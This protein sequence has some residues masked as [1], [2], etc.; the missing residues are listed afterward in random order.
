[1]NNEKSFREHMALNGFHYD[2]PLPIG[3]SV[4]FDAVDKPGKKH[5]W[6]IFHNYRGHYTDNRDSEKVFTWSL[7]SKKLSKKQRAELETT[8][9]QY[10]GE[11][12]KLRL[13]AKA[14]AEA[15]MATGLIDSGTHA[16]LNSKQVGSYGL[17]FNK[18]E[19][20]DYIGLPL[21]DL[22]GVLWN[23]QKIYSYKPGNSTNKWNLTGGRKKGCFHLIG[24]TL[25]QLS[26]HKRVFIVEGYATGATAHMATEEPVIVTL[27][28]SN[29]IKVCRLLKEA[30]AKNIIVAS[31]DDGL[32]IKKD[33]KNPG[34][35]AAK[36]IQKECGFSYIR[37]VFDMEKYPE[38]NPPS[39]LN[40]IHVH[41]GLAAVTKILT[42]YVINISR[43]E[44]RGIPFNDEEENL[45]KILGISTSATYQ[46]IKTAFHTL[47]NKY[48]PDKNKDCE[49]SKSRMRKVNLA[50]EILKNT[51]KRNDYDLTCANKAKF[52]QQQERQ[53]KRKSYTPEQ[54]AEK[55]DLWMDGE[56]DYRA[57]SSGHF[58]SDVREE[59]KQ[60][61][62]AFD[63]GETNFRGTPIQVANRVG[64]DLEG[65]Y[66]VGN[67]IFDGADYWAYD[68]QKWKKLFHTK[69]FSEIKSWVDKYDNTP[70]AD[71]HLRDPA[72]GIVV[73]SKYKIVVLKSSD[74]E[75]IKN[76]IQNKFA[77]REFFNCVKPLG[78]NCSNGFLE[79]SKK[80]E[81]RL[82]LHAPSLKQK[83]IIEAKWDTS[84]N[85]ESIEI[86]ENSLLFKFLKGC[87][88]GLS[89]KEFGEVIKLICEILGA[90]ASGAG[91]DLDLNHPRAFFLIGEK[92]Y[93]GKSQFIQLIQLFVEKEYRTAVPPEKFTD[94][95]ELYRLK[96]S[97][98]NCTNEIADAG[99]LS[100]DIFKSVITF[101]EV[102]A[103]DLYKSSVLFPLK[104]I[105][106]YAGNQMPV[107][108]GGW[109]KGVQRRINVIPFDRI[110]PQDERL[111]NIAREII[112][113][114]KTL[115]LRMAA[116][117]LKRI[118]QNK[119][120]T[121]IPS[122][123]ENFYN[124]LV[125]ADPFI[126]WWNDCVEVTGLPESKTS[127][128]DAYENFTEY[129]TD[130]HHNHSVGIIKFSQ[131]MKGINDP[132][133]CYEH[134]GGFRGF[135]GIKLGKDPKPPKI[136]P[137][138][139]DK[140]LASS[141]STFSAM[142]N[143]APQLNYRI[144]NFPK[145]ALHEVSRFADES[146]KNIISLD[147]ETTG[148]EP[149]EGHTAR[150]LQ[151][152]NG[153]DTIVVDLFKTG[154]LTAL[155][156]PL[157]RM[158]A[159]AHNAV[160]E[161]KF[162]KAAGIDVTLDCTMIAAHCMAM[163]TKMPSLAVLVRKYF[164]VELDK[165]YQKAD[166]S[167]ELTTKQYA[168]A[169]QDAYYTFALWKELHKEL[170]Q[171]ECMAGYVNTRDA[172]KA[173]VDIE[174][175]GMSFDAL[176]HKN[177]IT[178]LKQNKETLLAKLQTAMPTVKNFNSGKQLTVWLKQQFNHHEDTETWEKTKA[179]DLITDQKYIKNSLHF[180]NT[181]AQ[182]TLTN[183][184][185]PY[186]EVEKKL[187]T[188]GENFAKE[189]ISKNTGHIHSQV[190]L[191]GTKTGRTASWSPNIQQTPRDG[192][193]RKLYRADE[194]KAFV[195]A[196]YSQIELRIAAIYV[197]EKALLKAYN[198]EVDTH[199]LTASLVLSKSIEEVTKFDRQV[200]KAVNF[201]LL[202]GQTP[203]GLKNYAKASYDVEM[204]LEEAELFSQKW[205]EHY[206]A[207]KNWHNKAD[208]KPWKANIS[209]RTQ[210]GRT[211][212]F[213]AKN[214]CVDESGKWQRD[215]NDRVIW[216]EEPG[217]HYWHKNTYL[218]TPIQG[219]GADLLLRAIG[220][221]YQRLQ[222]FEAHLVMV[223]H[224]EIILE[225]PTIHAVH[226]KEVLEKAMIEAFTFMY[227]EACTKGLVEAKIGNSWGD[228]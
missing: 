64:L 210:L 104:A 61:V 147:L 195:I 216:D 136:A 69:D 188:Y 185:V 139:Q 29:L 47:A 219:T 54:D 43:F 113:K 130:S 107:F 115:L 77:N 87:F 197:Q 167:A 106:I 190:V 194:G 154:G 145:E 14:E 165:T 46:E 169:A 183:L 19:Y 198:D 218:N 28:A 96:D 62:L 8:K 84:W 90:V 150:L 16:Y 42:E 112:E 17:V 120:Y 196:D 37:P 89:E 200:A 129:A 125:Q 181:E 111:P 15:I 55:C 128:K 50:H 59:F 25:A 3:E 41:E 146:E 138:N 33:R 202:Y 117:G 45:Y 66:G 86:P 164:Y 208:K 131:R 81:V 22:E 191:C 225:V 175:T 214:P 44:G 141:L 148:L 103:R 51:K 82:T 36:K 40:D 207:F 124:Y 65:K 34:L 211:L 88:R 85:I 134:S 155:K 35:D 221:L 7:G 170:E 151:L 173:I 171:T 176:A 199:K 12:E 217:K 57:F 74:I 187:N 163:E 137:I 71:K 228:K 215:I 220:Q 121:Q 109:D 162:L 101:E 135:L 5:C 56:E 203:R 102:E 10:E 223:V 189:H 126:G 98:L 4:R 205:F 133:V 24:T 186:R 48:H 38:K 93:N 172:Q 180:L 159:V 30:G 224:D 123:Q 193:Y 97:L 140:G 222:H 1:M 13:A 27:D 110:I 100:C 58:D 158:K 192:D 174:L 204:T 94:K 79:F 179:G 144:I 108:K 39:D 20:G 9:S 6:L 72:T 156:E 178:Q 168:Y 11:K 213:C 78:I 76:T 53:E 68:G 161:M 75:L 119:D 80:G 209:V 23:I 105:H 92:A 177:L 63:S 206:P 122:F 67:V 21:I 95:F 91:R 32:K 142:E 212:N 184:Y 60:K 152:S 157:S 31:D 83:H 70:Y 160:F 149:F 201:G 114:E 127:T 99:V 166:W 227:P 73:E 153:I 182:N 226:V 2:G 132:Q 18:D 52:E 143:V 116:Y 26:S 49:L 118:L